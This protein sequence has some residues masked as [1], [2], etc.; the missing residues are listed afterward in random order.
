[1]VFRQCSPNKSYSKI[2]YEHEL[3]KYIKGKDPT[4]VASPI[5]CVDG[6][7]FF[8]ANYCGVNYYYMVF[9]Y[10]DGD[11]SPYTWIYNKVPEDTFIS[12]IRAIARYHKDVEGFITPSGTIKESDDVIIEMQHWPT[13]IKSALREMKYDHR[14]KLFTDYM[15]TKVDLV[16]QEV[17][18][19]ALFADKLAELPRT[20][21]HTD[22]QYANFKYRD[23]KA[24]SLFDFDWAKE[25]QRL[26]DVAYA[27][28]S[29]CASWE[30][31]SMGEINLQK[32][33]L[34]IRLYNEYM[35]RNNSIT[36]PLNILEI[37]MFP[38]MIQIGLLR[39]VY[40][41]VFEFYNNRNLNVFEYYLRGLRFVKSVEFMVRNTDKMIYLTRNL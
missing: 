3:L 18:R 20:H 35:R 24:I 41:Q 32:I 9:E 13:F 40:D 5:N 7:T 30:Y 39:V 36:G 34:F 37:E 28:K 26:Y 38:A 25:G 23:A 14:T 1:M 33:C 21:I 4:F 15:I 29:Y 6:S 12:C 8:Q 17:V 19:L 22:L 10:L 27:A 11:N 31:D 2:I 16:E